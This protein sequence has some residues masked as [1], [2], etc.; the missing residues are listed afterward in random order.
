MAAA[1]WVS[2]LD[3]L[4][5]ART[6]PEAQQA[7]AEVIDSVLPGGSAVANDGADLVRAIAA[8]PNVR[9]HSYRAY[10]LWVLV[11]MR[12]WIGVWQ[13]A[14]A[15]AGAGPRTMQAATSESETERQLELAAR[16][17]AEMVRDAD[18]E[19]RSMAY[20]L[21]G[22]TLPAREAV[23]IMREPL[24]RETDNLARACGTEAAAVAL[25]RAWPG[26][27]AD[28]HEWLRDLISSGG[29][30]A[31]GRIRHL[32]EGRAAIDV[33][34]SARAMLPEMSSD[35]GGL[36]PEGPFWPVELI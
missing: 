8:L 11:L 14:A 15:S 21:V 23:E 25:A 7:T 27:P 33:E 16:G 2:P 6:L 17:L 13:R 30:D 3:R 22:S 1:S 29:R 35:L 4:I 36:P 34:E 9:V 20:R 18:P 31:Q 26:I 28:S 24:V 19:V 5:D 12:R 10:L 32:L